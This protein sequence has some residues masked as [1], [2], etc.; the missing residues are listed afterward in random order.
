VGIWEPS[1]LASQAHASTNPE[2]ATEADGVQTTPDLPTDVLPEG[3]EYFS[4]RGE[5]IFTKPETGDL[6]IK[7]RQLPRGDGQRPAPF[8]LQLRGE[9]PLEHLRHFVAIDGRRQGQQLLVERFEVIAPVVQRGN[10]GGKGRRDGRTGGSGRTGGRQSQPAPSAGDR[11]A[12]SART[13]VTR[14]GR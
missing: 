7:V 8:K 4:L 2:P 9:I 1:T 11:P 10:R 3:D 5:L 6:V 12:A 14:P 13:A